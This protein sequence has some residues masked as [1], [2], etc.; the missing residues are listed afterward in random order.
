M[1]MSHHSIGDII[2][3]SGCDWCDWSTNYDPMVG[4]FIGIKHRQRSV[5]LNPPLV[6]HNQLG[7]QDN[8]RNVLSSSYDDDDVQPLSH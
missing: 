6:E 1:C 2:S 5:T 8:L 7:G 3:S 4:W